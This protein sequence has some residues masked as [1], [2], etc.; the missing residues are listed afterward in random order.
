MGGKVESALL[1]FQFA[2][3]LVL[4]GV[5][6]RESLLLTS[7][8]LAI[9]SFA[10]D[11]AIER[12]QLRVLMLGRSRQGYAILRPSPNFEQTIPTVSGTTDELIDTIKVLLAVNASPERSNKVVL[13]LARLRTQRGPA[14]IPLLVSLERRSLLAGQTPG[15]VEAVAGHLNDASPAVREQAART[16]ES[17]LEADY[18]EQATPREVAVRALTASLG[19]A[20]P[21]VAPR[22]AALQALGVAGLRAMDNRSTQALL[23]P[24]PLTTFAEQRARLDA[25]AQLQIAGQRGA[26]LA[27]LQRL[28]LDAPPRLQASAERAFGRLDPAGAVHEVT[29]RWKNKYNAGF[30][31]ETEISSLADL[32]PTDAVPALVEVSKLPLDHAERYAFVMACRKLAEKVSDG[33][34]IAPLARM[35]AP[36]ELDVRWGASEALMKIDSEDAAKALQPHLSEEANLLGKL[37]MAEFLGRHAI[38]DGYPYAIEHMS[39]PYLREQAI[40]ALAAIREPGAAGELRKILNRSNDVAWNSAAVRGLGRLGVAGLAP[41]FLEMARNT[42]NPLAPSALIALG[43]LHALSAIATVR[44]G[45]ASRNT[46]LLIASARAAGNL[47]ALPGVTADD[48]RNQLASLLADP[49]APAEARAAALDALLTVNDAR[50][51]HALSQAVRDGGLE[52]SDLLNKIEKL[53]RERKIKLTLP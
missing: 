30:S 33:R 47:V 21:Q 51:D 17:L 44:T 37:K 43:D 19:K 25:V 49:G 20:D 1:Q 24:E 52:E 36:N 38:R 42:K 10:N 28:P 23:R 31:V 16:L 26:V 22:V 40:A 46:E 48:V 12:G 35:L 29:R 50:L 11:S 32:L 34:L 4:K 39:E 3:V 9:Q 18:L 2:P 53:L 6:S 7:Q 5:F 13:L 27:V 45:L 8:D 14:V 41:Q 15:V